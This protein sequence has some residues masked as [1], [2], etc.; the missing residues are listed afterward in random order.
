M[1]PLIAKALALAA[2]L[3]LVVSMA[4]AVELV[5]GAETDHKGLATGRK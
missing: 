5:K 1:A 4:L 3:A 2:A